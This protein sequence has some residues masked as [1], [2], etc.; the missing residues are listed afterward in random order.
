MA[1]DGGW[2]ER[3]GHGPQLVFT[4][5]NGFPPETYNALLEN[6]MTRFRVATFANRPKWST[7]DPSDLASWHPLAA[8]LERAVEE[9]ADAPVV[10]VGHSLGGMLCALAAARNPE[11]FSALALF[12]P[13]VFSGVHAFVWGWMKR[14]GLGRVFPLVKGAEHR[15]D[16]WPDRAAVR[17]SWSGKRVFEGWDPR[18]F[19]DYLTAGVMDGPDGSV[20]LRYPKAW[21]A[22]IFEVCPSNEWSKLR[23]VSRPVLVIRGETSDTL[24][25]G[26]AGRMARE[27]PDATVVELRGTSHFLPM[28]KPD[29]VARMVIDFV[30]PGSAH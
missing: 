4:H 18:A 5:A 30:D 8:D 13:V 26:A 1:P 29:E 15:R 23:R 28:E 7:D 22:R 20:T 6:L 2:T 14:L 25:P 10:A 21:E 19:E 12:D 3:G 11:L 9:R 17:S 16:S 24:L 27:M